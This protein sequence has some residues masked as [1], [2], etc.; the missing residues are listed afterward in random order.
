MSNITMTDLEYFNLYRGHNTE[1]EPLELDDKLTNYTKGIYELQL[2]QYS[3]GVLPGISKFQLLSSADRFMNE[4]FK[5]HSVG[6]LSEKMLKKAIKKRR[7]I[8]DPKDIIDIYN[9]AAKMVD[10]F[11]IPLDCTLEDEFGGR[12]KAQ[13]LNIDEDEELFRE[14][15]PKF[16]LY[17]SNILMPKTLT[18]VAISS[19]VHEITHTQLESQ[20]GI[21]EEYYNSEVLSI[22]LEFLQGMENDPNS[23][24]LDF[25]NRLQHVL[26]NFYSMY[27]FHVGHPN[28]EGPYGE[29]DYYNDAHYVVSII[30]AIS[31]L[32]LYM[33]SNENIQNYM[34]EGI[35]KVFDG[36]MTLEQYLSTIDVDYNSS[37]NPKY[38]QDIMK[39]YII[40]K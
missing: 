6:F 23:F 13:L 16:N 28:P 4:K 21:V 14:L 37:L 7:I 25:V 26:V 32:Y 38:F 39:Q 1:L 12:L 33:T 22:F 24:S 30:K 5:L 31:M 20:K 9:R 27:M 36:K 15:L 3:K 8:L 17:F 10:P 40:K 35:Q 2:E 34:L 29:A 19:L 18:P 11:C